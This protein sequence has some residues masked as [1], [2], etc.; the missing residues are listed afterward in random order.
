MNMAN[1]LVIFCS[2]GVET[3]KQGHILFLI[4]SQVN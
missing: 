2:Q 1:I 4:S 3:A